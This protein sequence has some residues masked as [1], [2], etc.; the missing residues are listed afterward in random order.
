MHT[1]RQAS[2]RLG[3]SI[4]LLR[5]YLR[6]KRIPG[7]YQHRFPGG[8]YPVWLLPEDAQLPARKPRKSR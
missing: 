7:A 2:K 4:E 8:A 5:Y 3:C 6:L 1:V